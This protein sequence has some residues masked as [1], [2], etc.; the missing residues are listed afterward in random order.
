VSEVRHGFLDQII[1]LHPA[2]QAHVAMAQATHQAAKMVELR[3]GTWVAN[4]KM[5]DFNGLNRIE[6]GLR[7]RLRFDQ[8][9]D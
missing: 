5:W 3:L 2:P 8:Y 1:Q 4:K 6:T 7:L 9:Y